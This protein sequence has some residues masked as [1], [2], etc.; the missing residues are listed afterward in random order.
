MEQWQKEQDKL[1]KRGEPYDTLMRPEP[2]KINMAPLGEMDP[3]QNIWITAK[4]PL[5]DVDTAHIHLYSH[6]PTDS[7]WYAE[8]YRIGR[9]DS[10]TFV[11]KAAWKPEM[12]Y[13]LEIDSAA[14]QSIYGQASIA[15]KQGVRVRSL[16]KYATLLMTLQ[17]M[18]GKPVIAQLLDGSDQVVKEATTHNGQ[19]E[20]F[21]LKAGKYYMRMILDENQN[22]KWDTGDYDA[23]RQPEKV[24][25]YPETIECRAKWDLTLT[26]NP[27]A[28]P[29]NKQKPEQITKQ[30]GEKAKSIKHRNEERAKKLGI[31]YIPNNN[32]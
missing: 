1:K 14:F 7:L 16:D 5:N 17:G 32:L 29:F 31:E 28:R 6:H 22:G 18:E 20:F 19:A 9:K 25:Y 27:N 4:K 11:L 15:I 26:W 2:L 24:Y 23:D 8:P 3:D 13:S 30:K 10:Q 12:E 21:Y